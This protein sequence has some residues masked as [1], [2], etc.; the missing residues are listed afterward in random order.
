MTSKTTRNSSRFLSVFE[1]FHV[2]GLCFLTEILVK[3]GRS[4]YF[5]GLV[6]IPQKIKI[7]P[8]KNRSGFFDLPL[9][10]KLSVKNKKRRG[11]F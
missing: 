3:T 4:I 10:G 11:H 1:C 6:A 9:R 2:E 7:P 8:S 5:A